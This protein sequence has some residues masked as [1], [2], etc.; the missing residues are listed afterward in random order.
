MTFSKRPLIESNLYCDSPDATRRTYLWAKAL[1]NEVGYDNVG[2]ERNARME[3]FSVH[4]DTNIA[5]HRGIYNF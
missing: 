2:T 3:F 1:G 4:W 5:N